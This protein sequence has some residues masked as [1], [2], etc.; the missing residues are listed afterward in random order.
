MYEKEGTL[1]YIYVY[2]I[3]TKYNLRYGKTGFRERKENYL[4]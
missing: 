4:H 3:I 1:I 2:C